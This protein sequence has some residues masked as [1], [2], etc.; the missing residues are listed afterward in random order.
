ELMCC[1][2]LWNVLDCKNDSYGYIT[3]KRIV[4]QKK[5][6]RT[7]HY[8][9]SLKIEELFQYYLNRNK[10]LTNENICQILWSKLIYF[11]L[12][13]C[14][15]LSCLDFF[16]VYL[17][18]SLGHKNC[19]NTIHSHYEY[20]SSSSMGLC[21]R[22]YSNINICQFGIKGKFK[23]ILPGIYEILCRIKLDKNES[24]FS[25]FT[26]CCSQN[27]NREKYVE[28]YFIALADRGLDCEVDEKKLN[29]D[30]FESNYL[31]HGNQN[32]FIESMGKIKV[33]E[34]SN[35]YFGFKIT[36]DYG[37]RNILFDYIQLNIVE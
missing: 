21:V 34:L 6:P 35:I 28:C 33:F 9:M 20:D 18:C 4:K 26:E 14:K 22:L 17:R 23:S 25:Y 16:P 13:E 36:S 27:R 5:R 2:W 3:Y 11:Y 30:W 31:L 1:L 29:Y 24:Y 7:N 12:I 8:N 37:Y 32:W 15:R 19:S 10:Y